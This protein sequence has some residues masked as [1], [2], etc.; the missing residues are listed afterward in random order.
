MI[1]VGIPLLSSRRIPFMTLK[2]ER[3]RENHRWLQ[4]RRYQLDR[5][6]NPVQTVNQLLDLQHVIWFLA[7]N[8]LRLWFGICQA[9]SRGPSGVYGTIDPC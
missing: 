5:E 8:W 9:F 1:D 6:N 7:L 4:G 3:E 2:R